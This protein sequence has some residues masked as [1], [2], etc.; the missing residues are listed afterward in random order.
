MSK[1]K[2]VRAAVALLLLFIARPALAQTPIGKLCKPPMY[3]S[4]PVNESQARLRQFI[5]QGFDSAEEAALF[6]LRLDPPQKSTAMIL[7]MPRSG[8]YVVAYRGTQEQLDARALPI[9]LITTT[10]S[11]FGPDG[12]GTEAYQRAHSLWDSYFSFHFESTIAST[13]DRDR[14]FLVI[15]WANG[16]CPPDP[17]P[18]CREDRTP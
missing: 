17:D 2:Q 9:H 16:D 14:L 13:T 4:F 15:G 7:R 18:R 1:S 12:L 8:I 6:L 10:F 3:D 11:P 5:A